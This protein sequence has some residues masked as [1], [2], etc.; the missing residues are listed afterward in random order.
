MSIRIN[1]HLLAGGVLLAVTAVFLNGCGGGS[2]QKDTFSVDTSIAQLSG[3]WVG[4]LE[5]SNGVLR[6]LSLTIANGSVT[7][8]SVDGTSTTLSETITKQ[9]NVSL[10]L[11]AVLNGAATRLLVDSTS[12]YAVFLDENFNFGVVQKNAQPPLPTF[13][14]NDNDGDWAGHTLTTD[15]TTSTVFTSSGTCNN[16][17]CDDTGNGVTATLDLSA[18]FDSTFGNWT[19]SY[20]V[21]VPSD[22]GTVSMLMSDDRNFVGFYRC[23]AAGTFPGDCEFTGWVRQ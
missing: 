7:S 18:T 4:S 20:T 11:V 2:G 13:V 5:D 16:L 21:A 23:S 19:G 9:S 12:T 6:T 22:S 3:V 15:F 8:V 14:V 17:S 10:F 1:R